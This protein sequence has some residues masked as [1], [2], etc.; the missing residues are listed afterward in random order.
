[1]LLISFLTFIICGL[2][3]FAIYYLQISAELNFKLWDMQLKTAADFTV[4]MTITDEVWT[5]W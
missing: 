3:S 2:F 5:Q 4:Q 1:M